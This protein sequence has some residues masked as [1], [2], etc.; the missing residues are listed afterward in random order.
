MSLLQSNTYG[1]TKAA[2]ILSERLN[3][4]NKSSLTTK[5]GRLLSFFNLMLNQLKKLDNKIVI[6]I[7]KLVYNDAI[8]NA[9]DLPKEVSSYVKNVLNARYKAWCVDVVIQLKIKQNKK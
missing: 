7:S 4:L 5:V 3:V 8:A 6:R 9:N 1:D 2:V